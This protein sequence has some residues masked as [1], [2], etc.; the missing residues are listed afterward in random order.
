[1]TA[2]P[3][4]ATAA[5][6][7][8]EL[9]AAH[10]TPRYWATLSLI[11][12]QLICEIF[13]FFIVAFLVSA[14]APKW[15]LTYGESTIILVSAGI[16]SIVGALALGWA[17]D[18]FGR[19][20][21]MV[22]GAVLCSVAAGAVAFIPDKAWVLFAALRFLV[23]VGYGGAGAAQF[24]LVAEQTP[25]RFRTFMVGMLGMP[26]SLGVVLASV[27]VAVLFHVLGWRGIALLGAAPIVVAIALAFVAEESPR[28]RAARG[29]P[30]AAVQ[31]SGFATVTSDPRRFWLI[32]MVQ[33]GLGTALTGALLWGPTLLS[34]LLRIPP[35]KAAA[36]FIW[37]SL[38]GFVG[39]GIFS[40]VPMKIGRVASGRLIGYAG[41][42]C[43]ALAAIFHHAWL[44]AAPLFLVFFVIGEFFYDGGFSNVNPYAAELFPASSAARGTGLAAAAGGLGKFIGPTVLGL[45]AGGGNLI[46]PAATDH[47]VLPGFL[48]LAG[49]CLLAALAYTF[50]GI[51]TNGRP[52]PL[53]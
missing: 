25:T 36:A 13:D 14:V 23:G 12:I 30:A 45:L 5:N 6:L 51:E 29:R 43:L 39:R 24:A 11:V 3:A 10:L 44:G 49:C 33:M 8:A 28:W 2:D 26:A 42:A 46:T 47:A 37:V 19:K 38:A 22:G 32:V 50:L 35:Q 15:G 7:L 17:A 21:S 4:E 16:G 1:M 41:A 20:F 40:F 31:R 34:Q 53:E 9:D 27:S 48:F 52:I 18:R